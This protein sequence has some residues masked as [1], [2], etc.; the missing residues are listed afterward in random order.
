ME[1]VNELYI[2]KGDYIDKIAYIDENKLKQFDFIDK[3]KSIYEGD[4]YL[5]VVKKILTGMDAALVDLG[6]KE[7]GFLQERKLAD[8]IKNG[9]EIL[10]QIKRPGIDSKHPKLTKEISIVGRYIVFLPFS[11]GISISNKIKDTNTLDYIK[12]EIKEFATTDEDILSYALFPDVSKK[13]LEG[14]WAE[15]YKIEGTLY[16]S[17]DVTHPV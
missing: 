5:G 1:F 16:N 15:K 2:E 3:T 17:E 14:K 10:V 8:K 9:Q 6:N 7:I 13:F 11:R 12:N 4:I